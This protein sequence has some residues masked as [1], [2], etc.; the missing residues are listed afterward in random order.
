M[1]TYPKSGTTWTQE[2][3]WTLLHNPD[4]NNPNAKLSADIRSPHI[5]LDAIMKP[6]ATPKLNQD[7]YLVKMLAKA[8]PDRVTD[9]NPVT[10][11]LETGVESPRVIKSHLPLPLFNPKVQ[12]NTNHK[13]IRLSF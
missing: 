1:I 7:S 12:S 2:I 10:A 3:V 11:F 6:K 4:L 13:I 8:A 5:E 9:P